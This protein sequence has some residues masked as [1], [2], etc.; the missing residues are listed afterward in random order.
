MGACN[1]NDLNVVRPM[2]SRSQTWRSVSNTGVCFGGPM[3][4]DSCSA[5]LS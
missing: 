1:G 3:P 2:L 5:M 4:N